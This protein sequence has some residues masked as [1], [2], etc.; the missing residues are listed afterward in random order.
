MIFNMDESGIQIINKAQK[1]V[2]GKGSKGVSF[3][4]PR[5]KGETASLIACNN[6]EE[7]FLPPVLILKG[8]KTKSKFER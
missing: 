6:A 4:S 8:V 1:I 5:E 3:I 7:R 2:T